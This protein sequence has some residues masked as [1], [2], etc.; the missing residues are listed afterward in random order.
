MLVTPTETW[1]GVLEVKLKSLLVAL[2]AK[3]FLQL[4][5]FDAVYIAERHVS[6]R[7]I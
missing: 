2:C 5:P 4:C 1:D 3:F 6:S 7:L